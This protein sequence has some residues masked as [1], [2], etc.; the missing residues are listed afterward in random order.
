M[1]PT[2]RSFNLY[3]RTA[4]GLRICKKVVA[5]TAK[6]ALYAYARS[7]GV[8]SKKGARRAYAVKFT[9]LA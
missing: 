5:S 6:D 9:G 3:A 8:V 2:L 4:R 1:R 7:K